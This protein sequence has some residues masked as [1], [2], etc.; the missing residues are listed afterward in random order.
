MS[1]AVP[2]VFEA[3]KIDY[4]AKKGTDADVF[5]TIHE[6]VRS[7]EYLLEHGYQA[8]HMVGG[9]SAWKKAGYPSVK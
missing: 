7:L 9:F 3:V 2:A 4:A 1:A 5:R 8:Q 6:Q